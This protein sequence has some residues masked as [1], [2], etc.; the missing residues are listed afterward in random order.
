[1]R[2]S[3]KTALAAAALALGVMA[4]PAFSQGKI[5]V[6]NGNLPG[7]G[8]NDT[9]P[10]APIGGNTGVTLGEQRMNVFLHAADIWTAVLNPRVDIYVWARFVPLGTNVLGS[11][12]PISVEGGFDGAEYPDLWYHEALAN[13]LQGFDSAPH[14]PTF[15]PNAQD[16]ANPT[17]EISAR[18]ATGFNFYFGLDNNEESVPGTVDLL[19]VVLHEMGHGLGFSNLVNELDGS[20]LLDIGDVYSQYTIDDSTQKIWNSMTN[21]ERAA[22]A[23]NIRKVSWTGLHVKQDTPN[24]LLPGE[25]ALLGNS[26]GFSGAY[27]FGPA[28][29]GPVLD[30]TGVTGDVVLANDGVGVG[31]DAC[32]AL[33]AG[34]LTGKIGLVDRGVCAFTIKV[35][36]AQNAGAIAVIVADNAAGSPPP[37]LGGADATITIPSGRITLADG[38]ALKAALGGG[39]V[40]VT[41]KVDTSI[42]AGTDRINKLALLATFDP[43]APG[44]SISHFDGIAFPNQLMEPAINS[45]LTSS[46]TP[47]E[48]LTTSLFTDIGWYADFDGVPDGKDSCIG[49]DLRRTVY[50][51]RCNSRAGNDLM[52][53]GCSL[54][55]RYSECD[56]QRPVAYAACIAKKTNDFRKAKLIKPIEEVGIILCAL[57]NILH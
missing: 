4:S 44:S 15:L 8:F 19:A 47:P 9:T 34:S 49:S 13:H 32:E 33:P 54:A 36:N 37:G 21:A 25:P 57:D 23:L 11:A 17:D 10:A 39:T 24:V 22:S 38:N 50:F 46:V 42:L 18:F 27:L 12:G 43:V 51:G 29:F 30:A 28:G 45:D 6:V 41:M 35:K 55:D 1:M 53:D 52:A 40:N 20:K 3:F 7:V 31:S 5:I 26:G 48:D 16:Q 14:D 2:T 56:G